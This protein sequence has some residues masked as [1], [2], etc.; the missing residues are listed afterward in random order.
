MKRLL[1]ILV[2]ILFVTLFIIS[3]SYSQ[4]FTGAELTSVKNISCNG[5][6]DGEITVTISGGKAPFFYELYIIDGG[7]VLPLGSVSNSMAT[8]MTFGLS[9]GNISDITTGLPAYSGYRVRITSSETTLTGFGCRV[10]EVQNITLTEP[11]ALAVSFTA[12]PDCGSG[13]GSIDLSVSGGTPN[14]SYT[15]SGPTAIGNIED[16]TG[17]TAG[18]YSVLVT[19]TN[20]CEIASGNIVINAAPDATIAPAGPFC[21]YDPAVNLSAATPGGTWSGTGITDPVAGTF[22]PSIATAG[23][24]VITYS[25]SQNGC[26]IDDTQTIIVN[27][28]PI[29]P[30]LTNNGPLCEG[31]NLN[32][33]TTTVAGATYTWTG[34]NGFASAAQ[35][36][37]ISNVTAVHAGTYALTITTNGCNSA[38]GTTDV[39]INPPIAPT[40]SNNGPLCEGETLNLTTQAVTGAS[41]S[42]TGPNGFTANVQNPTRAGITAADAG[43]YFAT[44]TVNGCPGAAVAT[45]VVVNTTPATPAASNSGPVCAG[46]DVILSTPA[47]AGATYAWSGPN[48][49]TST[50]QNPTIVGATAANAGAY[51]VIISTNTCPSVAGTTTVIINDIPATPVAASN[52]P[53]CEGEELLLTTSTVAGATYSWTGPNSFTSSIQNPTIPNVLAA[54]A[55]TYSLTVTVA[56]CTSMGGT[57]DVVVN[58]PVAP[59][60]TNNGPLC[61]G[62]TLNLTTPVIAGAS[63]S[64][65]G[66]NGFSAN[67]QSPTRANITAA[68][69]GDYFVIITVNGCPGAPVATS[70]VVNPIPPTPVASNDGPVCAGEDI[71]LSTPTVAGATYAWT[72]PNGFSSVEQNPTLTAVSSVNEGIYSV[73]VTTNGCASLAGTTSVTINPIPETPVATNNGPICTGEDLLLSTPTVVGAIYAW[74]GPG[75][76]TSAAQNPTINGVT[77]LNAGTYSVTVTI[78]L[79][80]SIAGTTTV[81]INPPVNPTPSNNGP[82]CAGETLNLTTETVAGATYAWTGPN[83]FTANVQSPTRAGIT[84]ADAGDYFVSITVNG[85]TSVPVATNVVVNAP[86]ATPVVTDNGPI[87]EGEDILLATTTVTGATY[88]WAGP[89]GFSST[90]QNP[91]INNAVAAN[92]GTYSLIIT[93]NGCASAA[94][95]TAVVINPPVSPTP[96]NN[97]P[98]CEG[99][100]LNLTTDAVTG[101]TYSW[102]GPNGFIANLQSPSIGNITTAQAGDYFVSITVNGCAG[103]P[104]ATTVVINPA[105]ATPAASNSGP[106]CEGEDINLNTPTVTGATYAWSGPNGFSST[107]QNPTITGATAAD[108]G[109]YAVVI[110]TNG[111]ASIAGVTSVVINPIPTTPVATNNGPL[112]EGEELTLSTTTVAG[113][114]YAWV[115]PNGFTSTAQN[116]TISNVVAANAGTYSLTISLNGCTSLAGTT[117]VIVNPPI[118]PTPGNNGPLCEGENLTLTTDAV[119]GAT[120]SWTGPNGFTANVQNPVRANISAADAGDYDVIITV[121]GCPGAPVA[122]TVVVNTIPS[123]PVADNNGPLCA[124]Q[125]L[126]L[127]TPTVTGATYAWTGPNGFTSTAQ[128]PTIANVVASSAGN[129]AVIITITGCSSIADTT[130]VVIN[131]IPERP[132]A[133]SNGPLCEGGS[134]TLSTPTVAGATYA[135][136]GP[137]GFNTAVQNPI[138]N[139]VT[140]ANAGMYA[141]AVTVGGCASMAG[142]VDVIINEILNR[143]VATNNGPLCVGENLI[144]NTPFVAGAVYTWT[145]PAGYTSSAQNPEISNVTAANAGTYTVTIAVNGCQ[146]LAGNTTVIIHG[147]P[148]VTEVITNITT[149]GGSDGAI[150][151]T[152]T[153]GTAPFTYLWSNGQVVQDIAGLTVGVYEVVV[154]DV[155][156]C[157]ITNSYNITDPASFTVTASVTDVTG[158]GNDDGRIELT[159]TGGGTYTFLWSDGK[160]TQNNENLSGG[161]YSVEVSDENGCKVILNSTI[162]E[163]PAV[164]LSADVTDVSSCG[165]SDGAINLVV[166]GGTAP[167]TF[168][169]DNGATTAD[170]TGIVAGIYTIVVTDG[171]GC[172]NTLAITV[173]SPPT[174][175]AIAVVTDVTTCNGADGA[176]SID[177]TD[178]TAPF[179]FSWNNGA[180]TQNLTGL[181]AGTYRVIITDASG[182]TLEIEENVTEPAGFTLTATTTT[183][184]CTGADGAIDLEV[185]GG[186]AP[187]TYTWN[188]GETTEDLAGLAVGSYDVT[189]TDVNSCSATLS[190]DIVQPPALTLTATATNAT[191]CGATDGSI[192]LVVSGGT[193][194]F[195]YLWSNGATTEDIDNLGVNIYSVV[196]TDTKGCE[197]TFAIGISDPGGMVATTLVANTTQ[198]GGTDGEIDLTVSG[199]NGPYTFLWSNG[200]TTEDL[201]MLAAGTYSVI[202]TDANGCQTAVSAEV[203]DPALFIIA[204]TTEDITIC[205]GTDGRIDLTITGGSGDFS[206]FWLD[207]SSNFFFTKDL[208]NQPAGSYFVEVTDNVSLCKAMLEVTLAD[209]AIDIDA[210][211]SDATAC[212]V[213]DGSIVLAVT[214]ASA[215]LTYTWTLP[216]GTTATTT[217][218]ELINLTPGTYAVTVADNNFNACTSTLSDI[219]VGAPNDITVNPPVITAQNSCTTPNGSITYSFSGNYSF[220]FVGNGVDATNTTGALTALASGSYTV[221]ITNVDTGCEITQANLIVDNES[222]FNVEPAVIAGQTDCV[223]PNGSITAS[224]TGG[225]GSFAFSW[226]GPNGFVANSMAISSLSAGNYAVRITDTN[227]GCLQDRSYTVANPGNCG[228]G[229]GGP[230]NCGAFAFQFNNIAPSCGGDDGTVVF[231]NTRY[232]GATPPF[233]FSIRK[234]GDVVYDDQP[235][236]P[237]FSGY[238]TGDYEYKIEN[239]LNSDICTG[240]FVLRPAS[241]V[242]AVASAFEDVACFGTATGK[243]KI[244]IRPGGESSTGEYFY[245]SDAG[246]SW[247]RFTPGNVVSNLPPDGTYFILVGEKVN[248]TC[249]DFTVEVTI[250]NIN[251]EIGIAY[252]STEASCNLNDGSLTITG[253]TGGV[254][255]Y[256]ISFQNG[257]YQS[258]GGSMQFSNLAKGNKSVTVRDAI[259]CIKSFQAFVPAPNQ[260]IAIIDNPIDPSC[261]ADG[262]DGAITFTVDLTQTFVE[263]PYQF[264]ISKV[265][266][267]ENLTKYPLNQNFSGAYTQTIDTLSQG[268]YYLYIYSSEE[269]CTTPQTFSISGGAVALSMDVEKRD[270]ACKGDFGAVTI[271]NVTRDPSVSFTVEVFKNGSLTPDF[272][273]PLSN[274]SS[275]GFTIDET[276]Y[277]FTR[278]DYQIRIV[279]Q[280]ATCVTS[281]KSPLYE[282]S[283]AE[284]VVVFTSRIGE[285]KVSLPDKPTGSI[286]IDQIRGGTDPYEGRIIKDGVIGEWVTIEFNPVSQD[287]EILFDKLEAGGYTVD[288]RDARGCTTS[289]TIEVD[290]DRS[291]FIPNVFTP[292]DDGQNEAFYI[293]N[294]PPGAVLV[295]VN[296]WGKTVYET[297]DYKNDWRGVDL[298][299]A[300]YFYSLKV[301]ETKESFNGW[302][303]VFRGNTLR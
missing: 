186:T 236:D 42:W 85:C 79:C 45:T 2:L 63:Y 155:N 138:I 152:V 203:E 166:S 239:L 173:N 194:S 20:N 82:L 119:A 53:L 259:G 172:A 261:N 21:A 278:G 181:V 13:N 169:W 148:E 301:P 303:E 147:V 245:S 202:V 75:G 122:T 140:T 88:A 206:F 120:Y 209:P 151:L 277:A 269:S 246:V 205:G 112:C 250:N 32:L 247:T 4:C 100:T 180:T 299:D 179:T 187:F 258:F 107:E 108:A 287:Y 237:V 144:L 6:N 12:L 133:T 163:P 71:T 293:R 110:T 218:P 210:T 223:S 106:V 25:V 60:P 89:N 238:S 44:I 175:T 95:S 116:P 18:T 157:T 126:T 58:P 30:V 282:F 48:G 288:I 77:A 56:G 83:G 19:D 227:T 105:P 234:I 135:W 51:A 213:A 195:T 49:F 280:Q 273:L 46:E 168:A 256:Q 67:V 150:N 61:A 35:N 29:T 50:A 94:G 185:T 73:R 70:V 225:S 291:I 294:L 111:C 149:C 115:G 113:A 134:L 146:S 199:G 228:G 3:N 81:V 220:R 266:N 15:W 130:N 102:T 80:T 222:S 68:D 302:V 257:G 197:A 145:G 154:T 170:L 214:G 57:T 189:V 296:R 208:E 162:N 36:P 22:D 164:I 192:D 200:A 216:G 167:F 177:I 263:P 141:V 129:Y 38:V 252:S 289:Y 153:G 226:T 43:D 127:S 176:I 74:S 84:S 235:N 243:A 118:A 279:Q 99:E 156:G 96:S 59:T 161:N 174:F 10:R 64:W 290:V 276:L 117:D 171:A 260:V 221:T 193:G 286:K 240:N 11:P 274:V 196:V 215:D 211:V 253:V 248:D 26:T 37:T 90:D 281:I 249:P 267:Q 34:P 251:E 103:I 137:N 121:N 8:T 295:I 233:R 124:G 128:N 284:P 264:A 24:W 178:G 297:K 224:A 33:S 184:S 254:S 91:T 40:P 191:A 65:T 268:T 54:N 242:L 165:G 188:N 31:D 27:A 66:P 17:L 190:V 182:C 231:T 139:N 300:V 62:E 244:D 158:C 271:R 41:Y 87:C 136:T 285:V 72:G 198:C 55:G 23:S 78:N 104:V 275:N 183:P 143:P 5:G 232:N 131:P 39:I 283:I 159:I 14:Y 219:V 92:A 52:G 207:P 9:Q 97:G 229:G 160:T 16:P 76:F 212:N 265:D 101:A 201:E 132:V 298:P 1:Q 47:V 98:L 93:A 28:T 114:L 255:P 86:P 69:A 125:N 272:T 109:N 292:N 241:S 123:T 217:V 142:E 270:I 230:F 204:A 7:S 262:R